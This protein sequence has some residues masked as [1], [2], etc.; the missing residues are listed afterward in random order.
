VIPRCR[1]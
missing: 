1:I